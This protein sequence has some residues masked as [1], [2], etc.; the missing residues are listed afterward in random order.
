M[1]VGG[2][3]LDG[4]S[5]NFA[6]LTDEVQAYGHTD[7]SIRSR[8]IR[9][10]GLTAT[11]QLHS[12]DR[13][14]SRKPPLTP[15]PVSKGGRWAGYSDASL[16]EIVA[17]IGDGGPVACAGKYGQHGATTPDGSR[18]GTRRCSTI[19][20]GHSASRSPLDGG[21]GHRPQADNPSESTLSATERLERRVC[22]G[23]DTDIWKP[24]CC[25]RELRLSSVTP[26]WR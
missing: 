16:S 7:G 6:A 11:R 25:T 3:G 10:Q 23:T 21:N 22:L 4:P 20:L 13:P 17:E 2:H 9:A 15:I 19:G 5:T 8:L 1:L 12:A 26:P 18:S 24:A 14:A